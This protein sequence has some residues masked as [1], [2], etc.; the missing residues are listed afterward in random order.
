MSARKRIQKELKDF[1]KDPVPYCSA[2]PVNDSDFFH[3]EATILWPPGSPYEGGVFFLNITFPSDYPFKPPKVYFSTKII[4]FDYHYNSRFCC[5]C[6][7]TNML[8]DNWSPAL[9]ISK[10][11]KMI[12]GLMEDPDYNGCLYG[13]PV[14]EYKCRND[15]SYFE[16]IAKEWTKRYS[17]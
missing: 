10:V 14:N 9:T 1:N 2:S 11:L 7:R 6:D 17:C 16:A 15:H 13:Y 3:W 4:L 8:F 12:Y 5:E